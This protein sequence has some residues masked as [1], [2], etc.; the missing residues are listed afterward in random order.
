VYTVTNEAGIVSNVTTTNEVQAKMT[1]SNNLPSATHSLWKPLPY[2]FTGEWG[3]VYPNG[4]TFRIYPYVKPDISSTVTMRGNQLWVGNEPF[5]AGYAPKN[6][7]WCGDQTH[8]YII[9]Q[10]IGTQIICGGELCVSTAKGYYQVLTG[11]GEW[12][13]VPVNQFSGSD[14][15]TLEW[16]LIPVD[17]VTNGYYIRSKGTSTDIY[18]DKYGLDPTYA[19]KAPYKAQPYLKWGAYIGTY[20]VGGTGSI[21]DLGTPVKEY[22][23]SFPPQFQDYLPTRT[24]RPAGDYDVYGNLNILPSQMSGNKFDDKEYIFVLDPV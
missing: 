14:R 24:G 21:L 9:P 20:R 4:S 7:Y 13:N 17:W 19:T 18:Q 11:D 22:F 8:N 15:N 3:I 5:A 23:T 6:C 1:F 12:Q 16:E 10:R 2:S